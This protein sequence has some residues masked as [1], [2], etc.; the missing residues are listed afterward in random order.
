[1]KNQIVGCS[2]F[3]LLIALYSGF[4]TYADSTDRNDEIVTDS[5]AEVRRDIASPA[6]FE[7]DS[8]GALIAVLTENNN[9]AHDTN[10][11]KTSK[12]SATLADV[13][14]PAGNVSKSTFKKSK[15][16]SA[17]KKTFRLP[18]IKIKLSKNVRTVLIVFLLLISIGIVIALRI[19]EVRQKKKFMSVTR[20]S[21]MDKEIQKACKYIEQHYKESDL[22]VQSICQSL[23]TGEAFLQALFCRD[24]GMGVAQFID[25]VRVNRVKMI[26][27]AN[28]TTQTD[29]LP[30][31]VGYTD[32]ALFSMAFERVTGQRFENYHATISKS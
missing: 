25:Q 32:A 9:T 23:I 13:N 19:H 14:I 3:A 27:A 31:L 26:L 11:I 20:L 15:P 29:E 18:A 17:I 4:G 5:V 28:P 12:S 21:I 30:A 7:N 16:E 22:S 10:S 24:L 1:M 2:V 6:I 8:M